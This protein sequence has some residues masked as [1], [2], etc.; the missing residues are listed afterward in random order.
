MTIPVIVRRELHGLCVSPLAWAVLA[1][2]VFIVA[3]IFLVQV[4]AFLAVQP[5]LKVLENAPGLTALVAVPVLRAAG[6]V[7]LLL[8]PVLTMRTFSAELQSGS[9]DLLQSSPAGTLSIVL[10]KYLALLGFLGL[11]LALVSAM[12]L[13]LLAGGQLDL[14]HLAAAVLGV[15]LL[16]GCF[17]ALGLFISTLTTQPA[18]AAAMTYGLLLLLW[19]FGSG[20]AGGS[21]GAFLEWGSL[22]THLNTFLQGLVRSSDLLFYPLASCTALALAVRRLELRRTE[23]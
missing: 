7:A 23:G 21:L 2:A 17:A 11:L 3:W 20:S 15:A 5:R 14:G 22:R 13:T 9:F 16:L 8:V 19:L 4:D 18:M 6:G 12:P 10:G 1:A